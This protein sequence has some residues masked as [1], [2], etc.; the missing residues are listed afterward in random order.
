MMISSIDLFLSR[1]CAGGGGPVVEALRFTFVFPALFWVLVEA[2]DTL[3]CVE[4]DG[5]DGGARA[6]KKLDFA[7]GA[8]DVNGAP[9]AD[10]GA[11]SLMVFIALD[12]GLPRVEKRLPE[13]PLVEGAEVSESFFLAPRALNMLGALEDVVEEPG[14][15]SRLGEDEL[16]E[17][18]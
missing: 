7:A 10:V 2:A 13:A 9:A 1:D 4:A 5:S 6:P 16:A 15:N 11:G 18:L 3:G 8:P 17:V 12:E 14:A